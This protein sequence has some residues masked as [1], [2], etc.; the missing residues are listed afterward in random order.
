MRRIKRGTCALSVV[1]ARSQRRVRRPPGAFHPRETDGAMNRRRRGLRALQ[2]RRWPPS[3]CYDFKDRSPS[4]RVAVT[5][6]R[7]ASA[8]HLRP[9]RPF[10]N[11]A[12]DNLLQRSVS[13]VSHALGSALAQEAGQAPHEGTRAPV[14]AMI[15]ITLRVPEKSLRRLSSRQLTSDWRCATLVV[16]AMRTRLRA[17]YRLA[18][19]DAKVARAR[20][21]E[22]YGTYG[23]YGIYGASSVS[24]TGS[25][26]PA[27]SIPS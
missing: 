10:R 27:R 6:G 22:I 1:C 2:P 5:I 26:R 16:T 11:R 17:A 19:I 4:L 12:R 23:I 8:S 3:A 18:P 7:V 24:L 13:H 15:T 21:H 14:I 25:S 9:R 20:P